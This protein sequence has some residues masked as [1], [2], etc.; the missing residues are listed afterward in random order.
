MKTSIQILK[1]TFLVIIILTSMTLFA[2]ADREIVFYEN[3]E[4]GWGS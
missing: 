2:Q 1:N 4:I 3:F